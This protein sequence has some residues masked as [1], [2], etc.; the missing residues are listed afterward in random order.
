MGAFGGITCSG[1]RAD[2]RYRDQ[3]QHSRAT[4][5]TDHTPSSV[6]IRIKIIARAAGCCQDITRPAAVP[7]PLAAKVVVDGDRLPSNR[8]RIRSY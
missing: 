6:H 5:S 7:A 8:L 1:C 2:D 4:H 3:R